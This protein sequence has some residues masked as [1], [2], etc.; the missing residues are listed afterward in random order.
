[1]KF[2]QGLRQDVPET[3]DYQTLQGRPELNKRLI[4]EVDEFK[5]F[6]V[7]G[8]FVRNN[9]EIEFTMGSHKLMSDFIPK[10]EVWLD[11]R[12]SDNDILALIHHEVVEAR[13]MRKGMSYEDAHALATKSEMK[14]R[15]KMLG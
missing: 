2:E 7:N 3:A 10:D 8:E 1:M 9:L 4:D 5:V 15:K 11:D 12:M 6:L 14:F 13:L